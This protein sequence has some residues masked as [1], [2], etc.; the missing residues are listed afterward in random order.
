[1]QLEDGL[2]I[3]RV[4]GFYYTKHTFSQ[5]QIIWRCILHK[6]LRCIAEAIT[7]QDNP[8]FAQKLSSHTHERKSSF[9]YQ[10]DL[11]L[12]CEEIFENVQ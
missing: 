7:S 5:N 4:D 12:K 3:L 11:V 9:F 8:L 1:V 6:N 10:K 2:E